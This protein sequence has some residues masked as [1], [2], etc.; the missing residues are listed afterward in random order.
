MDRIE[1]IGPRPPATEPIPA[2]RRGE[3]ATDKR[4][5]QGGREQ[6]KRREPRREPPPEDGRPH[7]DVT[8]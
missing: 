6:P 8:V 5:R 2:V 3:S 4:E 7:V 1:P